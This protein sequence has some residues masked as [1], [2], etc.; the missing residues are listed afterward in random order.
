MKTIRIV[1]DGMGLRNQVCDP[2]GADISHL[3]MSA[4]VRMRPRELTTVRLEVMASTELDALLTECTVIRTCPRCL[5]TDREN[6]EREKE[7][8]PKDLSTRAHAQPRQAPPS[9]TTIIEKW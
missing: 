6:Y 8:N 2:D 4:D 5:Q 7:S 1:S 3:V 9:H